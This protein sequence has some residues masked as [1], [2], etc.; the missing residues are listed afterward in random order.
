M[1]RRYFPLAAVPIAVKLAGCLTADRPIVINRPEPVNVPEDKN[2]VTAIPAQHYNSLEAAILPIMAG[3]PKCVLAVGEIHKKEPSTLVSTAETFAAKV[4]PLLPA[5]G[6]TTLLTELLPYG[7]REQ[8]DQFNLTGRIEPNSLLDRWLTNVMSV[9]YCGTI[10]FLQIARDS[11]VTLYG[12]N[13]ST[14]E[15]YVIK[16]TAGKNDEELSRIVRENTLK[17]MRELKIGSNNE[18]IQITAYNGARQNNVTPLPGE[19]EHSFG[20][21][22]SPADYLEVDIY[23]GNLVEKIDQKYIGLDNYGSYVPAQGVNVVSVGNRVIIILSPS[24]QPIRYS[25]EPRP[26]CPVI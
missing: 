13:L 5:F 8:I 25:A 24:Q 26:N 12:T 4:I 18:G 20:Q 21:L 14:P 23:H 2:I 16:R 7:S 15:E 19:E 9:D 10:K 22:F 6:R 11:G 1:V 17:A 3:C